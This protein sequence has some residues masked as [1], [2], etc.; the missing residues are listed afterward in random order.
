M[1]DISGQLGLMDYLSKKYLIIYV[2]KCIMNKLN[3]IFVT[4]FF[5]CVNKL[6]LTAE[7]AWCQLTYHM[8]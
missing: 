3:K 4:P 8:F 6:V 1:K 7:H 5:F 2:Q